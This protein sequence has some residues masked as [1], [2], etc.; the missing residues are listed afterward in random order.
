MHVL[1]NNVHTEFRHKNLC[2][3]HTTQRALTLSLRIVFKNQNRIKNCVCILLLNLK[4]NHKKSKIRKLILVKCIPVII[5]S[6]ANF[7][8]FML[9]VEIARYSE[10]V[11]TY[12]LNNHSAFESGWAGINFFFV[13]LFWITQY[14]GW[15]NRSPYTEKYYANKKF[16]NFDLWFMIFFFFFNKRVYSS[17]LL[18]T[19][20]D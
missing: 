6:C 19:L 5:A 15:L 7:V 9:P 12:G 4:N 14:L 16:L 17:M 3:N 2:F 18:V 11:L 20:F 10:I 1:K 8:T 13:F